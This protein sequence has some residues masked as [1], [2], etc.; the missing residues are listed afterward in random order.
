[1]S[2]NCNP[3]VKAVCLLQIK[4]GSLS[5]CLKALQTVPEIVKLTTVTGD[6]DVIAHIEV[7]NPDQFHDI[8]ADFIDK[9]P[10]IE[11][12]KTYVVMREFHMK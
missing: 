9:I 1:M 2:E 11:N 12:T 7:D 4:P 5:V 3:K 10:G 8:F 6:C